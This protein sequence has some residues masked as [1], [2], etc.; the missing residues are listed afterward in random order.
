MKNKKVVLLGF[1]GM[2][3]DLTRTMIDAGKLPNFKRLEEQGSFSPLLSVFPADSIPSWITTFTGLDPS[4][5]GVL[6]HVNYILGDQSEAVIDTSV[7]HQKTFWDRIGAEAGASVCVINPFMAYPVWPV[8]GVMV[9]GPVFIAGDVQVSNTDAVDGLDIPQSIGGLE[10]LPTRETMAAFL[11]KAIH[12]TKEQA[13]FGVAMLQKNQPDFFFQTFLT[14]DRIQHFLWR[15]CDPSDPTH[16]GSNEV[17]NGIDQFFHEADVILGRFLDTLGNDDIIM[18]MSDHGHGMRCTHCFNFNEYFRRQGY[19][20]SA[21]GESK[22]NKKIIVEKLKNRVLK[23]LNDNDMEEYIGKIA[24]L[25]PNAKALKKGTHIASYHDSMCYAP[26]FAGSN[27]F[28]GVKINR[29]NVDD[30]EGFRQKLMDELSLIKYDN[31]PL[32]KW[33]KPR[34][35]MYNGKHIDRYPDILYEMN[36]RVGTGFAMHTDLFMANPTHK[37]ISG[38]HKKNGI[39]FVNKAQELSVQ[40]DDC[41]ISNMYSSILSL[42]NLSPKVEKNSRSFIDSSGRS[43]SSLSAG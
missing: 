41:K 24:K 16:P 19:L 10:D 33:L 43:T 18:V 22:L 32:F 27:P 26:D 9:S 17:E 15:Y 20:K 38:G 12:E 23:F 31:T 1:D 11:A 13:D 14:S 2:D 3:Y 29:E 21:S 37:K 25:V 8:N 36:P 35:S 6:D 34:E 40:Q 4:D 5:H 28:G 39:F 42:F 7:F 30:Y